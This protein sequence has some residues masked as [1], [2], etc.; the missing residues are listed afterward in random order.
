MAHSFLIAGE[1]EVLGG[2]VPS[3]IPA[4]Q[5]TVLRLAPGFDLS[6][7]NPQ[8]DLT[9]QLSVD[10]ENVRGRRAS[11]RQLNLDL[12]FIA[13]SADKL[14]AAVELFLSAINQERFQAVWTRDG[15]G[16]PMIFECL[17]AGQPQ[18]KYNLAWL[19]DH[20]HAMTV[21]FAAQPYGRSDTTQRL[22]FAS[23]VVG[24]TPPP[25]PVQLDD[26]STLGTG[27]HF[28][29]STQGVVGAHSA[30]WSAS[31]G[32]FP[33][34]AKTLGAAVDITGRTTLSFYFGLGASFF[35]YWQ[36]SA[37]N[38]SFTLTLTDT[39][40]GA[41]HTL[42]MGLTQYCTSSDSTGSPQ[43]QLVTANIP[44]SGTFD[45]AHVASYTISAYSGFSGGSKVL[46]P[47]AYFN[48]LFA[49]PATAGVPASSRAAIYQ[50]YGIIGSARSPLSVQVQQAAVSV[51]QTVT[52]SAAGP[53]TF[54]PPAGVTLL[55]SIEGTGGSGAGGDRTTT[56]QAGG[57]GGGA[58][59]KR[60]N[61]PCIPGVAMTGSNGAAG[62]SGA[63]PVN[64]GN[65]TFDLAGVAGGA[66]LTIN[67]GG[68]GP[69]NST[70]PGAGGA[71]SVGAGIT[72]FKGGDG[73]AG[74]TGSA[75]GGGGAAADTSGAG[76]NAS[77]ATGGIGPSGDGGNGG[78]SNNA[79]SQG[80]APG[81]A[82][83]GAASTGT[84]KVGGQGQPGSFVIKYTQVMANF[85]TMILHIPGPDAPAN[86]SPF[87][88]V[89]NAADP[90][91]GRE[92]N[93]P[94]LVAGTLADFDGTY[95]FV[96]CNFSWN[97]PA[98]SR[99]LTVTVRQYEF[100]G[101][102]S[103]SQ[104]LTRVLVPNTDVTNG[105]VDMGFLTLPN[106]AVPTDNSTGFYTVAVTSTNAADRFT[107]LLM[108][109][110]QGQTVKL[111]GSEAR[112]NVWVDAP[113][114]GKNMGQIYASSYDRS[115]AVSI[116][117]QCSMSG[118]P[119]TVYPGNQTMMAWCAEGAPGLVASYFPRWMIDRTV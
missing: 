23:S 61:Y 38:V 12:V 2:G 18:P 99:T 51:P 4:C 9:A 14:A 3:T 90:P 91:D 37:G 105:I 6:A 74:G 17:R 77:G 28:S 88:T 78:A 117:A 11:N 118:G 84:A 1:W 54:V 63:S 85:Q 7:P 29:A 94:S 79:G 86:L 65:T 115:Q 36:W 62:T 107:D 116:S 19:G 73:A 64:G 80:T 56:G 100:V 52:I 104:V 69:Q 45:F 72:S 95:A 76:T 26:F 98:A 40:G 58:W 66:G 83:G 110:S 16:L 42:T 60:T 70:T 108:L 44:A 20:M 13:P 15:S 31:S 46:I 24:G 57:G 68:S 47:D 67:G 101:G 81:G 97:T 33:A 114:I 103:T 59:A 82:G 87:A 22:E 96:L 75:G 10:G 106:R 53:F 113:V 112:P 32:G 21:T 5:G 41:G 102:P 27:A 8:A 43:W 55:T 25:A 109:D 30:H 93:V 89:G 119:P 39:T 50:L 71:A 111:D 35:S 48:D 49:A 34:Y 92:Y